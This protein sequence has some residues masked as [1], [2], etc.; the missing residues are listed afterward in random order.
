MPGSTIPPM[1][2]SRR[3]PRAGK[4]PIRLIPRGRRRLICRLGMTR[5]VGIGQQ[6]QAITRRGLPMPDRSRQ[7]AWVGTLTAAVFLSLVI[8]SVFLPGMEKDPARPTGFTLTADFGRVDG[9]VVGSPVR[10]AGLDVGRV[11]Q[12]FLT[13]QG[14]ANV[15]LSIDDV[16]L[17]IPADT[18]AVIETDGIF[19]EKYVELHPG[20]EF[21]NLTS[22]QRLSYSQD[23]VVLE[24]LL[25]QIVSRARAQ[26]EADTTSS[27]VEP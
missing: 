13:P 17:P 7:E 16:S 10:L 15:I 9:L 19:G 6:R 23:S 26:R 11:T 5:G 20:G 2:P 8:F 4:N 18:A 25:N 3:H 22:G 27:G 14:R 21:E 24:S 12:V 1:P